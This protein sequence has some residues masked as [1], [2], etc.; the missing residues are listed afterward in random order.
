MDEP[1]FNSIEEIPDYYVDSVRIAVNLYTFTLE[2]GRTG[3]PNAPGSEPPPTQRLAF[4]RMSPHHALILAKLLQKNLNT[5][6]HEVGRIEV[7]DQ[8]FRD[9]EIEP[10]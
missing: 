5:Y 10:D 1:L 7:P 4:V 9:L 6:Q 2:L 8:V 3:V